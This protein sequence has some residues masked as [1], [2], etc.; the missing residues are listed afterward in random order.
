MSFMLAVRMRLPTDV[1]EALV[2]ARERL[3]F[4]DAGELGLVAA[5]CSEES[6]WGNGTGVGTSALEGAMMGGGRCDCQ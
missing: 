4:G 1:L 2:E 6:G 5:S 3:L